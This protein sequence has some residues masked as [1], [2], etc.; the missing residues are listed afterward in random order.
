MF[1]FLLI[2]H[3]LH[4]MNWF[5]GLLHRSLREPIGFLEEDVQAEMDKVDAMTADQIKA[6]LLVAKHLSKSYKKRPAVMDVTFI[7]NR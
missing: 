4:R 6:H 5:Y 3:D 1:L 7:L 2:L